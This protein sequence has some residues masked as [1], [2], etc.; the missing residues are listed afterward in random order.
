MALITSRDTSYIF[1]V[2]A[3]ATSAVDRYRVVDS[4]DLA[5]PLG[6]T[7]F[8]ATSWG[9]DDG[10][11]E[12]DG[13]MTLNETFELTPLGFVFEL[14]RGT[15]GQAA[16]VDGL[17]SAVSQMINNSTVRFDV[18]EPVDYVLT[19]SLSNDPSGTYTG[20]VVFDNTSLAIPPI[21]NANAS[22]GPTVLTGTLPVGSYRLSGVMGGLAV[23]TNSDP[24]PDGGVANYDL[25]LELLVPEPSSVSMVA[26]G[27]FGLIAFSRRRVSR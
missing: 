11:A 14:T 21:L 18:I 25:R 8:Y 19:A 3:G 22:F 13:Q 17:G 12:A 9:N 5:T 15:D 1:D 7:E 20:Q 26:A 4:I 23:A 6:L 24:G 27:V 10:W 2:F 16:W